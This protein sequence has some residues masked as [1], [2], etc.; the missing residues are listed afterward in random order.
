MSKPFGFI[1]ENGDRINIKWHIV[2]S[3]NFQS[4]EFIF[5][6]VC[7]GTMED[8]WVKKMWATKL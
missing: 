6:L 8:C 7:M 5:S 1:E 4:Q 2:M 3:L